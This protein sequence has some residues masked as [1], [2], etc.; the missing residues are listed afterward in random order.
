MGRRNSISPPAQSPVRWLQVLTDHF[1][2]KNLA[3]L[4]TL[5]T[6]T[7]F[8]QT[9]SVSIRDTKFTFKT[10]FIDNENGDSIKQ[11]D[12]YRD[13]TKLLTH[14]ISKSE[15]DCNSEAIELGSYEIQDTTIIFYSYWTRAGDAPVSPYGVRIQVYNI[16]TLGALTKGKSEIY[17]ET[18]RQGW[19]GNKGINYLFNQ[20]K[21]EKEKTELN[22][23]IAEVEKEFSAKFVYDE[24]KNKL[25]KK[26]KTKL[27]RQ[28]QEKTKD[29]KKY[30]ADKIGGYKI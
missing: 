7:T 13:K 24:T 6:L 20:P 4:L 30:Y 11:L 19:S 8:G 14:T 22:E 28:I 18:S 25:L 12:I 27:Q 9:K 1:M 23:Y 17:I 10:Y 16:S 15:G 3:I 26:V 29:W 21:T 2:K 5:F